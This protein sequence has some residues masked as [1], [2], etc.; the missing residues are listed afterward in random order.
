MISPRL[1]FFAAVFF[2]AALAL[3]PACSPAQSTSPADE[4]RAAPAAKIK[5]K[6]LPNLG[7]VNDNLYRGGQPEARHK[8]FEQLRE[9]GID[10][11]VNLRDDQDD[12]EE[13]RRLV[14]AL[15]MQFVSI[16]WSGHKD[17]DNAQVAEFLRLVRENPD[18]QI[19][20]HCRRGAERTGV[21]LAA[22]RM[23]VEG[24]TPEQA[25]AEMEEFKFRGFWFR[26]LKRYVRE[27]PEHWE[28]EPAFA[29]LRAAPAAQPAASPAAAGKPA[30][31][32]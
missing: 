31:Q 24:W 6:G 17:P 9:L 32:P 26:H 4:A 29:P 21:M 30:P 28:N 20:V 3:T 7:R 13:E 5:A 14:E 8:A 2:A 27:F 1:R 18:K 10:I 22:Y 11:V 16:P 19:F 15:G 25:L 23:S 12:T